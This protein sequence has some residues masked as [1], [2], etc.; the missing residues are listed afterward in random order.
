[1]YIKV[2]YNFF[3]SASPKYKKKLTKKITQGGEGGGLTGVDR[4]AEI[5]LFLLF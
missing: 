4:V 5:I 1:M 2:L 3:Y